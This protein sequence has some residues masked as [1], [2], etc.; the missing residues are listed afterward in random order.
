MTETII[1]LITAFAGTNIDDIFINTIFFA[2]ADSKKKVR[3]VVAGKYL[4]MGILVLASLFGAFFLSGIPQTY[5][6]LLGLVP[7]ALGIKEIICNIKSNSQDSPEDDRKPDIS[8]GLIFSSALV[9]VSNGADNIGVYIPLFAGYTTAQ[10]LTAAAVFA[11]MTAIWCFFSK[12]LSDLPR[13]RNF[14]LKYKQIAVPTILILL[15][16]YIILKSLL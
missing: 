2:Q 11:I 8:K 3:A 16:A 15:G 5:I 7:I 4:G 14:L 10:M 6:G 13:L 9:T 1:S 12:K